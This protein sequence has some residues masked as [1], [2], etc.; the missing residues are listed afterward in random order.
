MPDT[1]ISVLLPVH[2][3]TQYTTAAVQSI[4]NQSHQ[5]LE[6]LLV[7]KED[8]HT[9]AAKLPT[10]GRIRPIARESAGV[11]GASN[12]GLKHCRGDYI[13]RMDSD[14]I[15]HPERIQIQ[16]KHAR[17]FDNIALIGA[18]VEI[19]TESGK[20]G[21]GNTHYQHWLN[22]LTDPQAISHACLIESP[23]PNPSLFAHKDY[24]AKMGGYREM[25]W[26][27]DYDLIL[28]TWLAGIPMAKPDST[29]LHWREHPESLTRTDQRYSRE[30]FIQAKAWALV[31][32]QAKLGLA[33]SRAVWLCGT[34]RNARFW[35]DAL[36]AND[37]RV[38]GFVELDSA[39]RKT[40]KRHLPV[41][42]YAEL[43]L[44]RDDAL[45]IT[46]VTNSAARV[47]L[48]AW[49]LEQQL[50]EGTDFIIGG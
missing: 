11:I 23:M 39:K 42:T 16:L 6:L 35:H 28:R 48:H 20:L 33:G 30:A 41:I 9:L 8:I 7:G 45:V 3:Y 47:A 12:T 49:L 14:D 29:L 5:H 4:L 24:W 1:L 26:P 43:A 27:E 22:S 50:N 21:N 2:A 17:Q 37:V 18:C 46:A 10:D 44:Q 34:G 36:V 15:C 38:M 31:Q 19:F 25:G 40:Q 32:P 13:A